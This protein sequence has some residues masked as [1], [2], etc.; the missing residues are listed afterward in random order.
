M[1][2]NAAEDRSENNRSHR[3]PDNCQI[4]E[5]AKDCQKESEGWARDTLR[6]LSFSIWIFD[7]FGNFLCGKAIFPV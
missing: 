5:I 1:E 4:A 2:I 6:V 7:I 3:D